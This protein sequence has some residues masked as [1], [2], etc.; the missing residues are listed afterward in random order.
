LGGEDLVVFEEECAGHLE[1]V[2]GEVADA[3]AAEDGDGAAP[4]DAGAEEFP[5]AAFAEA[6]GAVEL[7]AGVCDACDAGFFAE[8]GG[9][10]SVLEHVDEDEACAVGFGFGAEVFEA[11]EDLAGEGA[12]EVAEEDEGE[13]LVL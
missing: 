8:V 10:L 2:S 7:A 1:A 11:A 12:A 13:G 3:A 6:E 5:E 9:F 4:P